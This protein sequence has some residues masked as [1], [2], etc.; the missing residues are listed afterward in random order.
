[1]LV[2]VDEDAVV[3]AEAAPESVEPLAELGVGVAPGVARQASVSRFELGAVGVVAE[4]CGDDGPGA[5]EQRLRVAGHVRLGHRELQ[6]GEE[7]A[8]AAFGDV[9]LGVGVGLRRGRADRVDPELL[10]Q[11]FEF[12]GRHDR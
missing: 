3:A 2:R 8:L 12:S 1:M 10:G 5:G 7:A 11:P 6:V 9:A 4:R